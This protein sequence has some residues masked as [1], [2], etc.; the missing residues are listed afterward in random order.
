MS[1][2]K[3]GQVA[4]RLSKRLKKAN[5][6]GSIQ[7]SIVYGKMSW[8]SGK[9]GKIGNDVDIYDP[10]ELYEEVEEFVGVEPP[11]HIN[12]YV[13]Y[14]SLKPRANEGGAD[15]KFNDCLYRALRYFIINLDEYYKSPCQMKQELGIGRYN[16]KE[17]I[18]INIRGDCIRTSTIET[19]F[20]ANIQLIN[21]HYEPEKIN[22]RF[23][24]L[25]YGEEKKF[26]LYSKKDLIA[27]DGVK[28]WTLDKYDPT[29]FIKDRTHIYVLRTKYKGKE[30][31][32]EEE[33]NYLIEV[34]DELKNIPK[35]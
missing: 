30:F 4:N 11:K 17:K 8:R 13:L 9:F 33:Y 23:K 20:Q 15:D 29:K 6:E 28:K 18:Q 25:T 7:S 24:L 22:R 12:Q 10:N 19:N 14:L 1:L 34:A 2:E 21:G 5:I 27:Y 26:I 3:V 31:T 32:I 35:D 16:K